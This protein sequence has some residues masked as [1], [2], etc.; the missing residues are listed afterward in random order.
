MVRDGGGGGGG[1]SGYDRRFR[2]PPSRSPPSPAREGYTSK[3]NFEGLCSYFVKV[4]ARGGLLE[5]SASS[6]GDFRRR[7][8]KMLDFRGAYSEW[9]GGGGKM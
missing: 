1:G 2:D 3:R 9:E 5:I 7:S 8:V 6:F 4:T